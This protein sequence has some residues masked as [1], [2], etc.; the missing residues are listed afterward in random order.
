MTL[1]P[2][3]GI[4]H[5]LQPLLNVLNKH[6]LGAGLDEQQLKKIALE[7]LMA[8]DYIEHKDTY[9]QVISAKLTN[10]DEWFN[11]LFKGLM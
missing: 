8:C 11:V 1:Q 6:G 10:M 9:H 5:D 7:L 3:T 4:N 2:E